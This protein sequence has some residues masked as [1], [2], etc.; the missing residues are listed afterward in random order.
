MTDVS[1]LTATNTA[2]P[3]STV[4]VTT[5]AKKG[6]SHGKSRRFD[7]R[8]AVEI[9]VLVA[10]VGAIFYPLVASYVNYVSQSRA[11]NTYDAI[12]SQLSPAQR[13]R[14]WNAAKQYD[15]QLHGLLLNDPF[16]KRSLDAPSKL[17]WKTL[18]VDGHGM[19]AYVK[20]PKIHV[21]LP[22]YHGTSDAVLTKGTGHIAT[23]H[24]PTDNTTVHSVITGHTGLIGHIFFDNLTQLQNGDTFEVRVL[25]H[26]LTYKV[27][28]IIVIRPTQVNK[29]KAVE[30]KNYVT[31]MTCTP[32]G[33][34]DHRLLVRG[35][36]IGEAKAITQPTGL[37]LWVMW[38]F[39]L[40]VALCVATIV[41]CVKQRRHN[42]YLLLASSPQIGASAARLN[43]SKLVQN[44]KV[45]IA[46]ISGSALIA[47]FLAWASIGFMMRTGFMP[48]FDFG[49]SWW[50]SHVSYW[51]SIIGQQQLSSPIH[52]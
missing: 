10:G 44:N 46:V 19:M 21:E 7:W 6:T 49:Y 23:T 36:F 37:P 17:Y 34:N 51:F 39:L 9:I 5:T 18:N 50:D 1:S 20:I 14:M 27:D 12:V 26:R 29:L 24:L 48:A 4:K 11:I 33:V 31:S 2:R 28:S 30:G 15:A 3:S 8:S 52:W 41:W 43:E 35:R 40:G 13:A 16:N 42:R 45:L 32:Y 25:D 38:L 22:V 47:A